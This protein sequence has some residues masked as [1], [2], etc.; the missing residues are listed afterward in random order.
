MAF[1]CCCDSG[2]DSKGEDFF[3]AFD[4]NK[5]DKQNFRSNDGFDPDAF[6]AGWGEVTATTESSNRTQ[7]NIENMQRLSLSSFDSDPD[8]TNNDGT[9]NRPRPRRKS[10]NMDGFEGEGENT[11]NGPK[12]RR[13]SSE[14]FDSFDSFGGETD[15]NMNEGGSNQ[16]HRR[17]SNGYEGERDGTH[18]S[19][20]RRKSYGGSRVPRDGVTGAD[21]EVVPAETEKKER[22]MKKESMRND[23]DQRRR[24]LS[25][26]R[27]KPR[28]GSTTKVSDEKGISS[29][30][31]EKRILKGTS[32]RNMFNRKQANE[33][34]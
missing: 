27:R 22:R 20:P 15:N 1:R 19:K 11:K 6:G 2:F 12:P 16:K 24:S 25:R 32:I 28:R 13:K 34:L 29:G 31:A 26:S 21:G 9:S 4:N 30:D 7:E 8:K 23:D 10:N 18:R 3:Q 17:K 5:E 14:S 33:E